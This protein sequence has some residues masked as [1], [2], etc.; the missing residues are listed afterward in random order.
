MT[1][2]TSKLFRNYIRMVSLPRRI[3]HQQEKVEGM[4]PYYNNT[5]TNPFAY[6]A[7]SITI[8]NICLRR[9]EMLSSVLPRRYTINILEQQSR[10]LL[11]TSNSHALSG[12]NLKPSFEKQNLNSKNSFYR[13]RHHSVKLCSSSRKFKQPK[14]T[15]GM[16]YFVPPLTRNSQERMSLVKSEKPEIK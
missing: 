11:L 10:T 7:M 1:C 4:L 3:N 8:Y 9:R 2:T 13:P 15:D 16:K 12:N 5:F 14:R 6:C